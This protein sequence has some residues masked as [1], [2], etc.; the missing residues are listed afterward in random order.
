MSHHPPATSRFSFTLATST[1]HTH[2]TLRAN[3]SSDLLSRCY[4]LSCLAGSE[5]GIVLVVV[6]PPLLHHPLI[7]FI[8]VGHLHSTTT[9]V[10]ASAQARAHLVMHRDPMCHGHVGIHSVG[11]SN[12]FSTSTSCPLDTACVQEHHDRSINKCARH[13]T[14]LHEAAAV[15]LWPA[16]LTCSSSLL[17]SSFR[18]K[19]QP[20]SSGSA[21][22]SMANGSECARQLSSHLAYSIAAHSTCV[23]PLPRHSHARALPCEAAPVKLWGICEKANIHFVVEWLTAPPSTLRPSM[24]CSPWLRSHLFP[25]FLPVLLYRYARAGSRRSCRHSST[26][27]AR[28]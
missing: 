16:R 10:A 7:P 9:V 17:H 26:P 4:H 24:P 6:S 27:S 22:K 14:P 18:G 11:D 23:S 28:T 19:T 1:P 13:S 25:S 12:I 20:E 21:S 5:T 8:S 3:V 15:A 2:T